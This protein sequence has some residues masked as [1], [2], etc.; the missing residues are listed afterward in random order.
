[1]IHN[2]SFQALWLGQSLANLGDSFY[3]L[4]IV[5]WVYQLTHSVTLSS[6]FPLLR[7]TG[8][9]FSG[10]TAPLI[11]RRIPIA[12]L[13]F[14]SQTVQTCLLALLV[15]VWMLPIH[16]STLLGL[17]F[18]LVLLLALIDGVANPCRNSLVPRLVS[19]DQL[20]KANSLLAT[21]DQIVL[22]VGWSAGALLVAYLPLPW[23]MGFVVMLS[24]IAAFSLVPLT[25]DPHL[26]LV[27]QEKELVH[28]PWIQ[29]VSGWLLIWQSP[30]LRLVTTMEAIETL[31][32]SVWAGAFVLAFVKEILQQNEV[33]WGYI[34][35]LYFLGMIL[36]GMIVWKLSKWILDHLLTSMI[37]S[38][39]AV[40]LLTFVFTF[41]KIP[42]FTLLLVIIMGPFAQIKEVAL[43]S[44]IQSHPRIE[45]LP[46]IFS[47][48][49]SLI[50][51]MFGVSIFMMGIISDLLG[52]QT[53]YLI[54]SLLSLCS[55]TL[56]LLSSRRVRLN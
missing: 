11:M 33:W 42:W 34:N 32:S 26:D 53:V 37:I 3:T 24:G 29:M 31:A 17:L 18:V 43:K 52:I 7:V 40:S 9:F 6:L 28:S 48:Y 16:T 49:G 56:I 55:V 19:K 14:L 35:S 25:R 5:T 13:L 45:Q 51:V 8:L 4:A 41:C 12:R 50:A 38:L 54:A 1:M 44:M 27:N 22:V 2:R 21:S 20:V 30:R 23:V 10:I 15:T 46:I 47:A 39:L 36:G